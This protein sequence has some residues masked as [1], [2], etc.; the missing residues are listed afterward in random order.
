MSNRVKEIINQ[1]KI[2]EKN[3]FSST[4]GLKGYSVGSKRFPPTAKGYIEASRY[5]SKLFSKLN[6]PVSIKFIY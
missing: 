4:Q 3:I 6:K 2:N 5:A 1:I